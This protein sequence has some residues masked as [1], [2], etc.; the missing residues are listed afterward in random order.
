MDGFLKCIGYLAISG[1][2]AFLLGRI[3]PR[4]WFYYDQFP[5]RM[6][7]LE[8]EGAIYRKI[9]IHK[10]KDTFPDMSRIFP[11]LMPSKKLPRNIDPAQVQQMIVETCIAE[12]IHGFLCL[13]GL[14]CLF[15]WKGPGGIWAAV[16]YGLGNLPYCLIQ[17]YNRPKLVKILESVKRK[18]RKEKKKESHEESTYL[19]LQY[20]TGT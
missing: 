19:K 5:W 6:W 13:A 10:W 15:F 2:A 16:L 17:R 4:K 14:G 18:N 12:G 20:R 11:G 3:L 8:Q 1:I 7:K 9:R